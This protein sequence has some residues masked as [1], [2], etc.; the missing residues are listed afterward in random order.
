VSEGD[1]IGYVGNPYEDIDVAVRAPRR[2][3]II[4]RTTLPIVNLGD[5]LFHIAWSEEF[6]RPLRPSH[7]PLNEQS[8]EPVL[9]EDEII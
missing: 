5:A 4:G 7:E 8:A 3:L 6:S 9:D 1:I 2:G